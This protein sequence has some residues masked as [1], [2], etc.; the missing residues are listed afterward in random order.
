MKEEKIGGLDFLQSSIKH[1]NAGAY[2]HIFL[3]IPSSPL[4]H[5]NFHNEEK[6]GYSG[7]QLPSQGK[8]DWET[9]QILLLWKCAPS[10]GPGLRTSPGKFPAWCSPQ[11]I[12]HYS[13]PCEWQWSHNPTPQSSETVYISLSLGLVS[14]QIHLY[15]RRA[16]FKWHIFL[17]QNHYCNACSILH[18]SLGIALSHWGPSLN[19]IKLILRT[20]KQLKETT[21]LPPAIE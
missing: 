5:S 4:P 15:H 14:S 17:L 16:K 20:L 21:S 2:A 1:R 19:H 9:G 3:V 7:G 8:G 6:S 12:A 11:T 18:L 13:L 10:Q